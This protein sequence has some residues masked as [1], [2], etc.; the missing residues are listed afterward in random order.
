MRI[1]KRE[2]KP[3]LIP[4]VLYLLLLPGLLSL[5]FWQLDRA[6]EKQ[7]LR[8]LRKTQTQT[9]QLHFRGD[10]GQNLQDLLYRKIEIQG[11]FDLD[12]QF[13]LHNQTYKG[14]PGYLVYAPFHLKDSASVILVTRGWMPLKGDLQSV[15]ALPGDS[16]VMSVHGMVEKTPSVGY[17]TA[18]PDAGKMGW[19]RALSYLDMEWVSKQ[20]GVRLEPYTVFQENGAAYGMVRDWKTFAHNAEAMPPEKHTSYAVQWFALAITLTVIFIVVN[21]KKAGSESDQGE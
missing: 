18:S 12:H 14:M 13:L 20:L 11:K 3:G 4:T 17:K 19:P 2:F 9:G 16:G 21:L 10:P 1:G 6:A 7:K 5:G 15:P 8:D